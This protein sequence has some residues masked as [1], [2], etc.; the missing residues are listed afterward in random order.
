MN[1]TAHTDPLAA[2]ADDLAA[3]EAEIY[4]IAALGHEIAGLF[5]AER[6]AARE[7]LVATIAAATLFSTLSA[8]SAAIGFGHTG[9]GA[10]VIG[11]F[12]GLASASAAF[13]TCPA[14]TCVSQVGASLRAWWRR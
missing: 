2:L 7:R 6:R 4:G 3:M 9:P 11:I 5:D 14:P 10:L 1:R 8:T 12:A 13:V